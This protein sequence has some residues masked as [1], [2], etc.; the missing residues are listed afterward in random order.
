MATRRLDRN[1]WHWGFPCGAG[2]ELDETDRSGVLGQDFVF[3]GVKLPKGSTFVHVE[4]PDFIQFEVSAKTRVHQLEVAEGSRLE[5]SP[6]FSMPF[7]LLLLVLFWP[8]FLYRGISGVVR[9]E[10][11]VIPSVHCCFA[12]VRSKSRSSPMIVSGAIGAACSAS[13]CRARENRRRR[14]VDRRP[15][16]RCK[17]ALDGTDSLPIPGFSWLLRLRIRARGDQVSMSEDGRLAGFVL[18]EDSEIDGQKYER[19]TR[20]TLDRSGRV[21]KTKKLRV[22]VS[23]YTMRP[24]VNAIARGGKKS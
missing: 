21:R 20:I 19:G 10:V 2:T 4:T 13:C 6:W 8:L 15:R 3:R 18:S 14:A 1:E 23:L 12:R 22:D 16:L 11:T 9:G 5:F 7:H 24:E 17:R